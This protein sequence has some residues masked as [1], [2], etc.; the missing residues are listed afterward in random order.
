MLCEG[1]EMELSDFEPENATL[2]RD[3]FRQV[4]D[5]VIGGVPTVHEVHF[6]CLFMS[7]G[8]ILLQGSISTHQFDPMRP[9]VDHPKV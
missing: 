6:M 3:Y 7:L 5:I 8:R 2:K 1:L 4:V 9:H